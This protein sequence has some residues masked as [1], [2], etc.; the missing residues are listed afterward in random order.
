MPPLTQYA[1]FY[2]VF[3]PILLTSCAHLG[4]AENQN[5][6]IKQQLKNVNEGVPLTWRSEK[7][8]IVDT[9]I[10]WKDVAD[11]ELSTILAASLAENLSLKNTELSVKIGELDLQ[12]A[13]AS[14]RPRVNV[15]TGSRLTLNDTLNL[16]ESYRAG[17]A[18]SYEVD[19]W[20]R[21][22]GAIK[23]AELSYEDQQSFFDLA[24]IT[25]A[26][27]TSQI[28]ID[29]RVQDELIRLQEQQ[30][31]LQNDQ[32]R[33]TKARLEA[34]EITRLGVDQITVNI[35]SLLDGL[36]N[37]HVSRD[38]SE[39]ALATLLA[40]TP[41][42]FSLDEKAF[43]FEPIPRVSPETSITVLFD[44]P[45]I[46]NAERRVL[47]T[48]VSLILAR[49]A[50]LPDL[51]LSGSTGHQSLSLLDIFDS[52]PLFASITSSLSTLLYA[53]GDLARNV[54]RLD[55]RAEQA[56]N[57][58]KETILLS[59]QEIELLLTQR[60]QNERQLEILLLQEDAQERV[61]RVTQVQYE[62]GDASAFDLLRE[63]QNALRIKQ[64]R[65]QNWGSGM[66]NTISMLA[67]LGVVPETR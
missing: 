1:V 36:E 53:N 57:S 9:G 23:Q 30:I 21:V 31:A 11:D 55:F 6:D 67:A 19:L 39:R 25:V 66:R 64:T 2:L 44:R 18:V 41:D 27:R 47:S 60:R 28:Y 62:T 12:Q 59:L 49:K 51:I 29:I 35:Q 3:F 56:M 46:R 48:N 38:I 54:D 58:Y 32:L 14:K 5:I 24:K 26:Q 61:T 4:K 20:G 50:R 37:L 13:N 33:L 16:G 43:V 10:G 40:K 45:D 42:E 8:D 17:A 65:I 22:S 34:G 7:R 63:Q 15:D 52:K